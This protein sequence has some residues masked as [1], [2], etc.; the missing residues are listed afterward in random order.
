MTLLDI[1]LDYYMLT[2]RRPFLVSGLVSAAAVPLGLVML[3]FGP[4]LP[5]LICV[6]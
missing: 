1:A 6:A 3:L 2:A 4:R 5:G